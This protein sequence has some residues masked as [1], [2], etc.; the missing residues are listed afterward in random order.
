MLGPLTGTNMKEVADDVAPARADEETWRIVGVKPLDAR[1]LKAGAALALL[2][3]AVGLCFGWQIK[4]ALTRVADRM[5]VQAW[6]HETT[7]PSNPSPPTA[8]R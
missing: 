3:G 7:G 2:M 5:E 1:W 8:P 4:V 6:R